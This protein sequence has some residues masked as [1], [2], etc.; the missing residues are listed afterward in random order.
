M[1]YEMV[2]FPDLLTYY[3]T[4][5]VRILFNHLF[6]G[7]KVEKRVSTNLPSFFHCINKRL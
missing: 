5:L 4:T 2:M 1:D 7:I 3:D 6:K